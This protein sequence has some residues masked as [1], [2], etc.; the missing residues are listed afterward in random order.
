MQSKDQREI[1]EIS[2][3]S[4]VIQN[5]MLAVAQQEGEGKQ[6]GPQPTAETKG[7]RAQ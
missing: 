5:C 2:E 3:L 1:S 4:L 6:H 7:G